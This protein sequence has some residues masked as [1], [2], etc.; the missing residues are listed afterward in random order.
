VPDPSSITVAFGLIS[1]LVTN[2]LTY[3]AILVSA[4]GVDPIFKGFGLVA[5]ILGSYWLAG[6]MLDFL[7]SQSGDRPP[8]HK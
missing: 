5:N 1:L 6:K 4:D 3:L 8:R 7:K 2:A